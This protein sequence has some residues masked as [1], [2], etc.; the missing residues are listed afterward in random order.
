M[1]YTGDHWI[2]DDL[3]NYVKVALSVPINK[4][5]KQNMLRN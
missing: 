1:I 2:K 4:F 5:H 3:V